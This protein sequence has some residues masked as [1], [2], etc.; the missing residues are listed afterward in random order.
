VVT[1]LHNPSSVLAGESVL[2]EIG[3][4][5][6]SVGARVLV[7][8]VYLDA[9]YEARR[10]SFHLGGVR[11]DQQFDQSVWVSGLRCGWI[12]AE[13]ELRRHVAYERC[14]GGHAGASGELLSVAVFEQSDALR[15]GF[16]GLWRWTGKCWRSSGSHGARPRGAHRW[17]RRRF[18]GWLAEM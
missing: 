7:D 9:V 13:A 18:C 1:N 3:E 17:G 4:I 10:G 11:G 15:S 14:D 12:L 8:E 2:R 16:A 5:A 6:R